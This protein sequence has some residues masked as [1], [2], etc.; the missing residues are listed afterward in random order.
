MKSN[1]TVHPTG[2]EDEADVRRSE[3]QELAVSP[4]ASHL[5]QPALGAPAAG[6]AGV[7]R[8]RK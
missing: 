4:P 3:V 2:R 8:H 1:Q 6:Q 7:R 5:P